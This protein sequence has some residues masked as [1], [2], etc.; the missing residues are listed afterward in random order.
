MNFEEKPQYVWQQQCRFKKI[1]V[2]LIVDFQN[3]GQ[4]LWTLLSIWSCGKESRERKR[5]IIQTCSWCCCGTKLQSH[6]S[7]SECFKYL[8]PTLQQNKL[9]SKG[10]CLHWDH[11]LKS[12]EAIFYRPCTMTELVLITYLYDHSSSWPPT[13]F[14]DTHMWM[15]S[16]HRNYTSP[17]CCSILLLP[18]NALLTCRGLTKTLVAQH[19]AKTAQHGAVPTV[20][21]VKDWQSMC[22]KYFQLYFEL[23]F[24]NC[25]NYSEQFVIRDSKINYTSNRSS[26]PQDNLWCWLS[27]IYSFTHSLQERWWSNVMW[28]IVIKG[29]YDIMPTHGLYY[30]WIFLHKNTQPRGYWNTSY[31]IKNIMIR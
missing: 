26:Q 16:W 21:G 3:C 5:L 8:S 4:T 2:H 12:M 24:L 17:S 20:R 10:A 18:L 7:A 19:G 29:C 22:Q 14:T 27:Y 6:K 13:T 28:D 25:Y 1:M 9:V 15:F 30:F 23:R 11:A 31:N